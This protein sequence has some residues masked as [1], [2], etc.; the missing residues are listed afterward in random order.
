MFVAVSNHQRQAADLQA[1]S[2]Q[3]AK[4][5]TTNHVS[6]LGQLLG[7]IISCYAVDASYQAAWFQQLQSIQQ[8]IVFATSHPYVTGTWEEPEDDPF[9]SWWKNRDDLITLAYA[10][11]MGGLVATSVFVFDVSIQYV[12][13]LPDILAQ[14]RG[15]R[16]AVWRGQ[17]LLLARKC[18]S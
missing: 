15:F 4:A 18:G 8:L 5:V 9:A 16:C 3:N 2:R 11:G 17:Q 14:V 1:F 7:A 6:T 13:D 12:H 10:V